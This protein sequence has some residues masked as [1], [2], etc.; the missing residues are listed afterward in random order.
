M[1]SRFLLPRRKPG[2]FFC[3]FL[4]LLFG[5]LGLRK[6]LDESP[7]FFFFFFFWLGLTVA[8]LWWWEEIFGGDGW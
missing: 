1:G 3:I 2:F 8:I 4:K 6:E 7:V 5:F